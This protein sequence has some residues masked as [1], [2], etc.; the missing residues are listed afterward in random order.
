[1]IIYSIIILVAGASVYL[2]YGPLIIEADSRQEYYGIRLLGIGGANL[3]MEESKIGIRL[4]ILGINKN[5]FPGD[6]KERV[7]KQKKEAKPRQFSVKKALPKVTAVIRSFE[8]KY[9]YMN[10]DTGNYVMNAF[11]YPLAE[12]LSRE[13]HRVRINFH[14]EVELRLKIVNSLQ[15]MLRAFLW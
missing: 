13:S 12:V 2:L 1:M 7:Q 6:K 14:G 9:F 15:R 3:I 8:V 4:N 5:I 10:I 11:F